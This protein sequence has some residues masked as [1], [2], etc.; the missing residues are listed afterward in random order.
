MIVFNSLDDIDIPF[1]TCVTIGN[2]DGVHRGHQTLINKAIDYSKENDVKSVV[3]TF[4]NHP[5]N[6]F[7]P[8]YVKNIISAEEKERIVESMGVDIYICIPFD[9][10]MTQ[11]SA[12]YYVENILIDKLHVKKMVIGHDFSFA[13]KKEGSPE[14]LKSFGEEL[15]FE[16][17]VVTPVLLDGKRVSST[18]IRKHIAEGDVV[19][20]EH[21]L[22]RYFAVE[23]K[24]VRGRQ[25]GRTIGFPTANMEYE[26][27]MIIPKIGIYATLVIIDNEIY[28]GATSIG[29]N[30]TVNGKKLSVE[31]YILDFDREIYDREIRVEFVEKMREEIK[32]E[33]KEAL[34]EQ[35]VKDTQYV[36]DNYVKCLRG[37]ID[38]C[39]EFNNKVE[40]IRQILKIK[41]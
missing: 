24:V 39:E 6:F 7:K 38:K 34:R 12:R 30:P 10:S 22:G 36:R 37:S 15:K 27:C 25:I 26:S 17:E 8:G 2:F 18:D 28:C 4:S 1:E 35:L 11:I 40:N 20:A 33:S 5:V 19:A 29:T 21:L 13:R 3:F 16:V 14:L 31:T 9:E 41:N 32:F 23:G